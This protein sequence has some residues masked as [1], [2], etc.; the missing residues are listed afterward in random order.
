MD[1]EERR[2]AP[3][4]NNSGGVPMIHQ[5]KPGDMAG[6]SPQSSGASGPVSVGNIGNNL[7]RYYLEASNTINCRGCS[8]F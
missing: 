4:Q 1:L 3:Y 2:C 8:R 7:L 6:L 5:G